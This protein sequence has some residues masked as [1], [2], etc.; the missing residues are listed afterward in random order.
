MER[1]GDRYEKMEGY[2]SVGQ[3]PQQAVVPVEEEVW[4]SSKL[5]LDHSELQYKTSVSSL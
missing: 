4:T 2:C 3:N 5:Q 1:F